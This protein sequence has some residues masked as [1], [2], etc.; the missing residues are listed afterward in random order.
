MEE[1][2][3]DGWTRKCLK[4]HSKRKESVWVGWVNMKEVLI[5]FYHFLKN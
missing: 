1:A 3:G 5:A 4:F 2:R